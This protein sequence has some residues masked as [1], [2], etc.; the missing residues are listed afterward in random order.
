MSKTENKFQRIYMKHPKIKLELY[1][2]VYEALKKYNNPKGTTITELAEYMDCKRSRVERRI[3]M[4]RKFGYIKVIGRKKGIP[5]LCV[6][7][8]KGDKKWKYGKIPIGTTIEDNYSL[9]LKKLKY[10]RKLDKELKE[11]LLFYQNKKKNGKF[12]KVYNNIIENIWLNNLNSKLNKLQM[13]S[14]ALRYYIGSQ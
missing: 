3:K 14:T 2:K 13:G 6:S 12:F 5:Y 9:L 8:R 10:T 4:L 7:N 1:N 11:Q